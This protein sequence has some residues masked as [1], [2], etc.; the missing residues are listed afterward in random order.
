MPG[1]TISDAAAKRGD[2][3]SEDAGP[4][5]VVL[6]AA[7]RNR[8]TVLRHWA[9]S[10]PKDETSRAVHPPTEAG[11]G[12]GKS[13]FFLFGYKLYTPGD[14]EM[15]AGEFE[16]IQDDLKV[17][18]AAGYTVVVDRAARCEDLLGAIAGTAPGVEGLAPAG[19]YWSGHGGNDGRLETC[20][21]GTFGPEDLDPAT[22]ATGLRV[23]ILGAC[24]VGAHSRRWRAAL[25][26]EPLVVGW[27]RPVTLERAIDFLEPDEPTRTDLDDLIQ[28]WLLTEDPVPPAAVDRLPA[29]VGPSA[30]LAGRLGE[31]EQRGP[32][33]AAMLG[34]YR[35]ADE[36]GYFVV[37][38]LPQG[39]S[40]VVQMF[41]TD[42][43]D[44][45]T[46]GAL[47]F[48]CEAA[49]GEIT[50]LVTPETL[51]ATEAGPG[52]GRIALVAN[53]DRT[54]TMVA[55]SF[56]PFGGTADQLL[57][58]HVYAVAAKADALEYAIFGG[59]RG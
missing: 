38:P 41:L 4:R 58:A 19:F 46:E 54:P 47:L 39:R 24:Y 35:T 31:L 17:L 22:V 9:D 16:A 48:G 15:L 53:G 45:F 43:V 34:A 55:Q 50:A 11:I 57:A 26:G 37:V 20:D 52:F 14:R 36:T 23:A 59:D 3:V 2:T 42:A 8:S 7:W 6:P 1:R 44:P 51:L 30:A 13:F 5:E 32:T 27:G 49:A 29:G 12:T 25:G 28:R 18:T 40:H 33:I 10:A 21:G 56:L